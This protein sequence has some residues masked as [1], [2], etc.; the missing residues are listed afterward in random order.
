M[1]IAKQ[2]YDVDTAEPK[3]LVFSSKLPCLKILQT[4]KVSAVSASTIP[5]NAVVALPIKIFVF[6][7]NSGEYYPVAESFDSTNLYL[8]GGEGSGAYYYYF[9]CYA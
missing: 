2:G 4:G 6:R 8:P 7:E 1:K 3:D 9:I 5:F